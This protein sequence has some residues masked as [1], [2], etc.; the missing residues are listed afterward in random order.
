MSATFTLDLNRHALAGGARPVLARAW[1]PV[2]RPEITCGSA[3]GAS[4][5]HG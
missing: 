1:S 4:Y 2:I 3:C 5:Y